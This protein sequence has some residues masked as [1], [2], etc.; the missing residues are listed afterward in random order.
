MIGSHVNIVKHAS[1]TTRKLT[2][3][4]GTFFFHAQVER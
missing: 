1:A 3:A 2:Q 4:I